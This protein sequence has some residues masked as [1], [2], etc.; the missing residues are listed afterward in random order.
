[1]CVTIPVVQVQVL[2]LV[3]IYITHLK[4]FDFILWL[5]FAKL[6]LRQHRMLN[7]HSTFLEMSKFDFEILRKNEITVF[8]ISCTYPCPPCFYA[9][10]EAN[11]F[12]VKNSHF[13]WLFP[14]H[15]NARLNINYI[16]C[17]YRVSCSLMLKV[18]FQDGIW[19]LWGS[20][21]CCR[22]AP[23]SGHSWWIQNWKLWKASV[24]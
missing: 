4:S 22:I 11:Y 21:D 15:K 7:L 16:S 23:H 6:Q 24:S 14:W 17:I 10:T 20:W 9:Y 2:N 5:T 8:P 13:R 12:F 18:L 3:F 19:K 1:M